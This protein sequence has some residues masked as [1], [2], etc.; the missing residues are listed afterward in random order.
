MQ[1]GRLSLFF[2]SIVLC[3]INTENSLTGRENE[4][5]DE[6]Q[7]KKRQHISL[8]E[9][10]KRPRMQAFWKDTCYLMMLLLQ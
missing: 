3:L 7:G 9:T 4:F 6:D 2:Q 10:G 8:G 1:N 5:N